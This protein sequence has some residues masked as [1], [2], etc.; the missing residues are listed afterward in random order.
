MGIRAYEWQKINADGSARGWCGSARVLRKADFVHGAAS[1]A[2]HVL[3][4][5]TNLGNES[6][7]LVLMDADM[8]LAQNAPILLCSK[9]VKHPGRLENKV[10]KH[11]RS[12]FSVMGNGC[13]A[14][15]HYCNPLVISEAA[16]KVA[17]SLAYSNEYGFERATQPFNGEDGSWKKVGELFIRD[18]ISV[19]GKGA[20]ISFREAGLVDFERG[21]DSEACP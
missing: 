16:K 8:R 11:G 1:I 3:D 20:Y 5:A 7:W 21:L 2:R 17:W 6:Y 10:E 4:H 13:Y 19:D 14:V 9:P 18:M 15:V 12:L